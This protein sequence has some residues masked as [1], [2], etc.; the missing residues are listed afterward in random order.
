MFETSQ[1]RREFAAAALH[2][3]LV[4]AIRHALHARREED[5]LSQRNLSRIYGREMFINNTLTSWNW[6]TSTICNLA[7]AIGLRFE[8][9]F[10][11]RKNPRR[12]FTPTGVEYREVE[13]STPTPGH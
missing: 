13:P 8:F 4:R 11:D 1:Q 12:R 2:T 6:K 10:V 9:A 3:A 7:E 5:G